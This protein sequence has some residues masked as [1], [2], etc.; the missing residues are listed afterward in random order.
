MRHELARRS[1]LHGPLWPVAALDA[2]AASSQVKRMRPSLLPSAITLLLM[3]AAAG[4]ASAADAQ[5]RV[6]AVAVNDEWKFD[7]VTLTDGK[8]IEGLLIADDS[9]TDIDFAEVHRRPGKPMSIVIRPLPRSA[10][11]SVM[12]LEPA[13]RQILR[14]RLDR[15]IHRAAIE[16]RRMEDLKLSSSERDGVKYWHYRGDWFWLESS[17]D[18]A[19]TRRAA[20]RLEQVF[21]GYRQILPPRRNSQRRL[22]IM[23]FGETDRYAAFLRGLGLEITNPAFFAADFNIVAAGSDVNR[24]NEQLVRTRATH[25]AARKRLEEQIDRLPEQLRVLA[26]Q[27]RKS[28][29]PDSERKA[30][31]ASE[32]RIWQERQQRLLEDI[33]QAERHNARTCEALT[34][35]MFA[36]LYHEAFHAYL[37][38]YVY[39]HHEYDVPRWLNEGLAMTFEGGQLD[40]DTLRIDAPNRRALEVLQADLRGPNAMS[41][42]ELLSADVDQFLPAHQRGEGQASRLYAYSWGL[43][44][45]LTFD[46]S[47]VNAPGFVKYIAPAATPANPTRRFEEWTGKSLAEFEKQWRAAILAMR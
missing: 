45:Y 17:T 10:V 28:G 30:V 3:L 11:G 26:N 35:G 43:A 37:D 15:F 32:Q 42:A 39:P 20:V 31:L 47:L 2:R 1:S 44:Y 18:E 25:A 4:I 19:T 6:A 36:R 22:K 33:A 29:V 21:T 7:R 34:S 24:L 23:L 5:N 16:S 9:L 13:E 8:T 41:L 40:G 12:R 14:Q 38:N 46:L 27:M